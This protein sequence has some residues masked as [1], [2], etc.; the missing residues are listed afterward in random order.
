MWYAVI[1]Q[2]KRIILPALIMHKLGLNKNLLGGDI[3]DNWSCQKNAP[4]CFNSKYVKRENN[5]Y[6]TVF[7]L[8]YTLETF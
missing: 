3:E 7:L 6:A 1:V 5:L 8:P 4:N 2:W